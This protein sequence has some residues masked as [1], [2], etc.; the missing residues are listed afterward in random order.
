MILSNYDKKEILNDNE[1]VKIRNNLSGRVRTFYD[2][3]KNTPIYD[4]S[5]LFSTTLYLNDMFRYLSAYYQNDDID[6]IVGIEPGG[7]CIGVGL[8][9]YLKKPFVPIR[10]TVKN[11]VH[12]ENCDV[13]YEISKNAISIN[14][15]V[16][17]VDNVIITGETLKAANSL[18]E[19]CKSTVVDCCVLKSSITVQSLN[20]PITVFL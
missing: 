2:A 1:F 15:R 20:M 18:I 10:K 17:L 12:R 8:S 9:N 11:N 7:F 4:V 16:L 6:Y 3:I 19:M 13:K 14:S 5:A